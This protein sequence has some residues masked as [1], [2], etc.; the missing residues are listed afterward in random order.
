MVN[1]LINH[2]DFTINRSNEETT[3]EKNIRII[4]CMCSNDHRNNP[5]MLLFPRDSPFLWSQF[6]SSLSVFPVA[7]MVFSQKMLYLLCP[8]K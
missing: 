2:I 1:L 6:S 8:S 4:G 3:E 7:S 5:N